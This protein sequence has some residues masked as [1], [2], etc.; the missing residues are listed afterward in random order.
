MGASKVIYISCNPST[1]KRDIDLF[2]NYYVEEISGF[3][4]FPLTK[5]V[6]CVCVIK[7]R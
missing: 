7:R 1:L 3:N 4:M 5:H 6:E 2:S